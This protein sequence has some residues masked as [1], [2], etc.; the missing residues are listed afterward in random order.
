[1]NY[2]DMMKFCDPDDTRLYCTKPFS[3]DGKAYATDVKIL[4]RFDGVTDVDPL[5]AGNLANTEMIARKIVGFCEAGNFVEG[6]MP[7]KV[8]IPPYPPCP[9]CLGVGKVAKEIE[10]PECDGEGEVNIGKHWYECKECD[11]TGNTDDDNKDAEKTIDCEK[12]NGT[13]KGYHAVDVDDRKFQAKYLEKI[14]AL[15]NIEYKLLD[16]EREMM[17]FKFDGGVGCLMPTT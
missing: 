4:M 3:I 2:S 12:C 16:G 7:F 5:S 9:M 10:C 15:P 11:G 17:R 8:E 13:G 14:L 1:M 6:F